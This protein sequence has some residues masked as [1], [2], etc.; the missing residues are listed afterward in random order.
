[1]KYAMRT[2]HQLS[3]C[4]CTDSFPRLGDNQWT[5]SALYAFMLDR[6]TVA[7]YDSSLVTSILKVC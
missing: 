4:P 6:V 7:D 1:M 5:M 3:A 2:L